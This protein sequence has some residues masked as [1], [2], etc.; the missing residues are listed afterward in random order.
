MSRIARRVHQAGV[1]FVATDT[2]QR[3]ELFQKPEL[4]KVV[5]D[6]IFE[7]R[8]RGFYKLHAFVLM[9]ERLH[10]LLTPGEEASLEKAV[11]MIK[12]GSSFKIRKELNYKFLIWFNGYHD[13]WIRDI[14]EYRIRKQ[15]IERNP[16]KAQLV[17]KPSDY[18]A[19]SA[20]GEH[21]MD[22]CEFDE[23]SFRC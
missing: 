8:K 22:P 20:S 18:S 1:Y 23:G 19:G 17:E 16:V 14:A 2:W 21:E 5:L 12:G 11:M 9:P 6:Q 4:A 7:C 10:I 15:Y 3:R 13:R